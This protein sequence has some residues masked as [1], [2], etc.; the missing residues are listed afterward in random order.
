MARVLKAEDS[1]RGPAGR[2][3]VLHLADLGEEA[4]HVVLDARKDAARIVALAR[5]EAEQLQNT[6]MRQGHSEGLLQ[7]RREGYEAGSCDAKQQADQT[8][9]AESAEIMNFAKSVLEKLQSAM[10]QS[11]A[12]TAE[13]M[14]EFAVELAEKIVGRVA[15]TEISAARANLAKA[16]ELVHGGEIVVRVNP[17]QLAE[18]RE[19]CMQLVQTLSVEGNVRMVGDKHV[20]AGGVKIISGRGEV[21]ATIKTQLDNV[22]G[23]LLG[24][25][26]SAGRY[27]SEVMGQYIGEGV[28]SPQEHEIV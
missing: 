6:A 21:D 3:T 19:H 2:A 22:V 13:Q 26:R 12:E 8:A 15:V 9:S 1:L 16:L 23:S 28:E 5:K 25:D 11:H 17:Q 10:G 7:G 24:A 4:R 18:L 20:D 27:E 14:L